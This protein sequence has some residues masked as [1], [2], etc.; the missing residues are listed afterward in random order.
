MRRNSSAR[1][2]RAADP[3]DKDSTLTIFLHAAC[4]LRLFSNAATLGF[5]SVTVLS[6]SFT[7]MEYLALA[8]TVLRIHHSSHSVLG[9]VSAESQ[10]VGNPDTVDTPPEVGTFA[11]DDNSSTSTTELVRK[12]TETE[13]TISAP[14]DTI[15]AFGNDGK[16]EIWRR[17]TNMWTKWTKGI[18]CGWGYACVKAQSNIFIL[19]GL[20]GGEISTET[21]IYD[22]PKEEWSK[23]PQ[24]KV[25]RLDVLFRQPLNQCLILFLEKPGSP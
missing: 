14:T 15:I 17:E 18:D 19:G 16:N 24:L 2:F 4:S 20:R 10:N 23:G 25:A 12:E 9:A 21:D 8:A 3:S 11:L 22:I 1:I 13:P 6:L 7:D 5:C